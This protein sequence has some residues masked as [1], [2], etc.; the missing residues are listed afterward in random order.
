S[1]LGVDWAA[2]RYLPESYASGSVA[3]MRRLLVTFVGHRAVVM[4]VLAIAFLMAATPI[5]A[6]IG[7]PGSEN[8]LRL[9][10]IVFLA[11][12]IAEFI[13][14]NVFAALL[15]QGYQLVSQF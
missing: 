1:L 11:D 2:F 9:Y 4:V 5:C 7:S 15:R 14:A 6:L 13:R 10:L 8:A 12:G 3:A